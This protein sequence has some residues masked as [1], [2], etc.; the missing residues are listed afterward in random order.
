M[1]FIDRDGRVQRVASAAIAHPG[2]VA[3][4]V[5]VEVADHGCRAGPFRLERKGVRVGLQHAPAGGENLVLVAR[6]VL[7]PWQKDLPDAVAWM[8]PH[9]VHAT[10]PGVEV[11]DD[12]DTVRVGG[13]HHEHDAVD[14]VERAPMR[15]EPLV[16]IVVA[17]LREQV[18]IVVGEGRR[19]PVRIL[20]DRRAIAIRHAQ[21]VCDPPT[22]FREPSFWPS[23]ARNNRAK[24][25]HLV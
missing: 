12:A 5:A 19:K 23:G 13:P 22:T 10:V 15:A 7:H 3:P 1:D 11:A 20:D 4:A 21:P 18:Q 24:A 25:A 16:R 14:A 17:A 8:Q 2:V 9:H 6:V